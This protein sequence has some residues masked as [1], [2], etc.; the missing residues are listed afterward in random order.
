MQARRETKRHIIALQTM[1]RSQELLEDQ[2]ASM[3]IN[4]N[5]LRKQ[6][7]EIEAK[8][9]KD[10]IKL[11]REFVSKNKGLMEIFNAFW[12]TY[13]S[14]T[15]DGFLSREGYSKFNHGIQIALV[16]YHSFDEVDNNVNNDWAHDSLLFGPFN[17]QG[18]FDLLFE[19]IETWTEI[20]D[21]TYYAAFAWSLLDSMADTTSHP[22]RLRPLREIVCITKVA[23][24]AVSPSILH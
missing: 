9:N 18:F 22:P 13:L 4:I 8:V 14:F 3:E 11:R 10:E 2:R 6:L 23:N 20:V 12:L 1:L 7:N 19:T 16:G 15:S 21:P 17:K 5:N 24:E